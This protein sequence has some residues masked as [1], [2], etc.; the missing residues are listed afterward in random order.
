MKGYKNDRQITKKYLCR[1]HVRLFDA[2]N[3][4]TC[5]EMALGKALVET[6]SLDVGC[7]GLCAQSKGWGLS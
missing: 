3:E 5:V 6:V 2:L 4:Q 1:L 7:F